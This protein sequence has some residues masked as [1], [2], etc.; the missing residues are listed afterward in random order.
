MFKNTWKENTSSLEKARVWKDKMYKRNLL[1]KF[2]T[3]VTKS[4]I[5]WGWIK[6]NY[7][8]RYKSMLFLKNILKRRDCYFIEE[9]NKNDPSLFSLIPKLVIFDLDRLM[10]R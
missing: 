9:E 2:F 7:L 6:F 5:A 10:E 4:S 3:L 8:S 1:G